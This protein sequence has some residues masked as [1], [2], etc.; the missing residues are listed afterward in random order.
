MITQESKKPTVLIIDD[1]AD[2]VESLSEVLRHS[3]Y[4]VHSINDGC[5]LD[6]VLEKTSVQVILLDLRMPGM[7]GFEVIR[8]LKDRLAPA[9]WHINQA[10]KII[11]VTGRGEQETADFTRKLGADAYLVKPV[12]PKQLLSTVRNVLSG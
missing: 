8:K 1:D 9:R 7:N 10:A 12:D 6:D 2:Y 3:G 4:I 5:E 11:V